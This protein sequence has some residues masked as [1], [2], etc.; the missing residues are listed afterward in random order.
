MNYLD[1]IKK[2]KEEKNNTQN[3]NDF[4]LKLQ[5]ILEE[6]QIILSLKENS[7]YLIDPS[8]EKFIKIKTCK[9]EI[10]LLIRSRNILDMETINFIEIITDEIKNFIEKDEYKQLKT[11]T[12]LL[13]K[14]TAVFIS[15]TGIKELLE[16]ILIELKNIVPYVSAN[17]ALLE[18]GS[19]SYFTFTG[20]EKYNA[21]TFMRNFKMDK[22]KFYT[23][24]TVLE[25]QKPVLVEDT[26]KF[27]Y[28]VKIPETSW[29]KSHLM[30]PIL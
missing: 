16:E 18:K 10:N 11:E 14:L 25:T 12:E 27:P 1:L 19:L 3:L 28:W 6:K 7:N 8:Y 30:I 15:K 24:R 2:I 21:D 9:N 22:E 13:N 20:Y 29:I 17:I 26:D 23:L 5:E 4:I